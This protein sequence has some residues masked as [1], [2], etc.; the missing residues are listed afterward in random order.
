MAFV[1]EEFLHKKMRKKE[2]IFVNSTNKTHWLLKEG[3]VK[4]YG[5]L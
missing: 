3:S 4:Q 5:G 2:D 1:K